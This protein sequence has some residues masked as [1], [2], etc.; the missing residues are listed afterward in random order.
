MDYW[1]EWIT[2]FSFTDSVKYGR[3]LSVQAHFSPLIYHRGR[4]MKGKR[5][6]LSS[7][8]LH[9]L[10]CLLCN[11]FPVNNLY[12]PSFLVEVCCRLSQ[13][14][15]VLINNNFKKMTHSA[16]TLESFKIVWFFFQ[17]KGEHMCIFAHDETISQ[18]LWDMSHW[19]SNA[20]LCCYH[21]ENTSSHSF[22][23]AA[24]K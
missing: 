7:I 16:L 1:A 4:W 24:F 2:R 13:C 10:L 20:S 5:Q 11:T 22:L 6:W 14:K 21:A 12:S 9:Y 3:C 23:E 15:E 19:E 17:K 18:L 8:L